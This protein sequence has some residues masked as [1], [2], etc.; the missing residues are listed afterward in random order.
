ML[1]VGEKKRKGREGKGGK[2]GRGKWKRSWVGR[3]MGE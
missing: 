2:G 3:R 1:D